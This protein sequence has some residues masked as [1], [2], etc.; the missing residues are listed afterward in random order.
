M[1]CKVE[2]NPN[3]IR[4]KGEIILT[5]NKVVFFYDNK[6]VFITLNRYTINMSKFMEISVKKNINTS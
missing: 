3:D 5:R 4:N 1:F 6:R 2:K